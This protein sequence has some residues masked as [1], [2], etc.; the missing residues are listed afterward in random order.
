MKVTN[1]T[2]KL[3]AAVVAAGIWA[4]S[5]AYATNIPLGDPSFEDYTVPAAVGYAYAAPPAGSYRPTSA[6][7]DDL[8]SPPG[9]TQDDGNSNWLYNT[10]YGEASATH[11]RAAPRTGTQAMHTLFNYSAQETGAVFEAN[12]TYSF[13]MWAQGDID[14]T[15]S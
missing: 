13:S 1:W 4:P 2:K 15:G 10:A 7:V 11:R 8:D 5:M 14:A 6:W 9:Y 3:C 12:T